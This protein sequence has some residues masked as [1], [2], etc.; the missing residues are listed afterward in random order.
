[1]GKTAEVFYNIK[2]YEIELELF[3]VMSAMTLLI[4]NNILIM[5]PTCGCIERSEN[6]NRFQ[7]SDCVSRPIKLVASRLSEVDN[8]STEHLTFIC[9]NIFLISCTEGG[10]NKS[11]L[12]A[13]S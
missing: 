12:K 13:Y 5:S 9:G 7:V 6:V 11:H 2:A 8:V 10:L 3:N 4:F 1:M